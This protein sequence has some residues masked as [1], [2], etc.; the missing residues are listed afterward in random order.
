MPTSHDIPHAQPRHSL[1]YTEYTTFFC[2]TGT[3]KR[4]SERNSH[5]FNFLLPYA[6]PRNIHLRL[7]NIGNSGIRHN[8]NND[9]QLRHKFNPNIRSGIQGD[10]TSM[11]KVLLKSCS[12]AR[13]G[14]K[15]RAIA[16]KASNSHGS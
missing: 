9:T 12:L 14:A 3:K 10:P 16:E 2:V 15:T 8:T 7:R 6:V 4:S 5:N 13:N 11:F 1:N